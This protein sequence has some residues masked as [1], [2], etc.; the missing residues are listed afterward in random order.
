D[1][2][3]ARICVSDT[4]VGIPADVGDRIFEPFFSV[5][6]TSTQRGQGSSG[7]G[8]A[9]TRRLV[10]A[11]GGTIAYAPRLGGGTTFTVTLP[12]ARS[13]AVR[14]NGTAGRTPQAATVPAAAHGEASGVR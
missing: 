13:V 1:P 4:G 8:L 9:L 7:L 12:L 11:H 3:A 2:D 14:G 10:T 6:G 5:K